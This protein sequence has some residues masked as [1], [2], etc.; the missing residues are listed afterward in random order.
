MAAR[1][2]RKIK[3]TQ[4]KWALVDCAA[5][6]KLSKY[7][8]FYHKKPT[9][10]TGYALRWEGNAIVRMHWE[11]L[12]KGVDHINGS[13]VD[14]RKKNLRF[15]SKWEQIYNQGRRKTKKT[16]GCKGVTVV[17][18]HKGRPA[19]WIVRIS[20][21]GVRK[22][23]GTFKTS[24]AADKVARRELKRCHGEFARW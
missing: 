3:L 14:N 23:L 17:R 2:Y 18:D 22:Y 21:K 4:G 19:Y 1:K 6:N 20:V 11:V 8:W 7:K 15:A 9:D 24:K 12:G 16:P 5:Y 13:G 10:K